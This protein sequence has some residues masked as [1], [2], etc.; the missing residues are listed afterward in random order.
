MKRIL[1]LCYCGLV[2]SLLT[3]FLLRFQYFYGVN[4]VLDI[5]FL[6]CYC[7]EDSPFNNSDNVDYVSPFNRFTIE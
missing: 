4:V 3:G 5:P 7:P 1:S 2:Q 6:L